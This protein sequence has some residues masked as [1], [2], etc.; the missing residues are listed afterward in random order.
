MSI[1]RFWNPKCFVV[2]LQCVFS[3][4]IFE[5]IENQYFNYQNFDKDLAFFVSSF[6]S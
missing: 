4:I 5:L 3:V 1:V 6:K 2:S